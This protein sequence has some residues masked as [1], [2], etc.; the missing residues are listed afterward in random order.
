MSSRPVTF[1]Q[2]AE[3][4][5]V[6]RSTV[7]K[8]LNPG[9]HQYRISP[10]TVSRVRKIAWSLG[11]PVSTMENM[12]PPGHRRPLV[13]LVSSERL[14]DPMS[15][16]GELS[17]IMTITMGRQGIDLVMV[18]NND[19]WQQWKDEGR[20]QQLAGALLLEF[21]SNDLDMLVAHSR[22]PLF[23]LNFPCDLPLDQAVID[24]GPGVA[25]AAA[26]LLD[27]GHR[28]VLY[29]VPTLSRHRA[30]FDAR[31]Q[32]LVAA[33]RDGGGSLTIVQGPDAAM[34]ALAAMPQVT[35]VVTY[36]EMEAR[37]LV[38]WLAERG[39]RIPA[40]LSILSLAGPPNIDW[41]LPKLSCLRTPWNQIARDAAVTLIDRINGDLSAPVRR[42]YVETLQV[43][44]STAPPRPER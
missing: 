11:R 23:L 34:N 5:G 20:E 37:S 16:Y 14:P 40:D 26:Y 41:I 22:L 9:G 32:G 28:H 7:S 27:L 4:A 15:C 36:S 29:L 12:P 17:N 30:S 31:E 25:E 21:I 42:S 13:A 38:D 10:E 8:I 35:V 19:G 24:H 1:D 2:I 3:R 39:V 33:I 44:P 6:S 43:R 18:I